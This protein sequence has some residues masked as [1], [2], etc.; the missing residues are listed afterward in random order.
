MYQ[1]RGGPVRRV[2]S[3]RAPA[4]LVPVVTD[5]RDDVHHRAGFDRVVDQMRIASEPQA[6]DGLAQFLAAPGDGP[7]NLGR[8]LAHIATLAGRGCDL[9]VLGTVISVCKDWAVADA[10]KLRLLLSKGA[11]VK[12]RALY[13][14]WDSQITSE[15]RAQ[16]R[17][18]G[19]LTAL[20]YAVQLEPMWLRLALALLTFSV[21]CACLYRAVMFVH[22]IAHH[23]A[24]G[25][26]SSAWLAT[27]VSE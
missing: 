24:K 2:E 13:S 6:G 3:G 23:F 10:A 21:E 16:Y 17:P 15:P 9:V 11:S 8:A 1:R 20:L 19:G 25:I 5:D 26:A 7:G 27:I 18:V 4:R 22:E 14:D 12:P